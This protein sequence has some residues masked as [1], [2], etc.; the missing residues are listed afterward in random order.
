MGPGDGCSCL[1]HE[2]WPDIDG[3]RC[4]RR[5]QATSVS[6]GPRRCRRAAPQDASIAVTVTA[7]GAGVCGGNRPTPSSDGGGDRPRRH[8][9]TMISS[10]PVRPGR[11]SMK[12]TFDLVTSEAFTDP[13]VLGSSS[14]DILPLIRV[15]AFHNYVLY[16]LLTLFIYW[17]DLSNIRK[18]KVSSSM[19]AV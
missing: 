3:A 1:R 8:P 15:Y 19:T 6:G 10:D 16:L 5:P 11:P 17:K 2:R 14:S 12:T 18:R 7:R 13:V 9:K 4:E